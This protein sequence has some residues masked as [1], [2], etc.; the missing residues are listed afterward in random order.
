[1][2]KLSQL[3]IKKMF[4]VFFTGFFRCLMSLFPQDFQGFGMILMKKMFI[5]SLSSET[6]I[7]LAYKMQVSVELDFFFLLVSLLYSYA[8]LYHFVYIHRE[9]KYKVI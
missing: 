4:G 2:G 5:Q 1:M 8:V 7:T 9:F 6:G 3:F